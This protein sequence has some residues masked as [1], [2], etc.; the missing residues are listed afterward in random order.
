MGWARGL[1]TRGRTRDKL[2]AIIDK[3]RAVREGDVR[4]LAYN[5]SMACDFSCKSLNGSRNLVNLA[6][7]ISAIG[8]CLMA[9]EST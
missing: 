2:Y 1:Q 7:Q 9:L 6:I 5:I 8:L 3:V 4:G